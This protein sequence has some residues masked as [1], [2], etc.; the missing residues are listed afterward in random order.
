MSLNPVTQLLRSN[1]L[2][3]ENLGSASGLQPFPGNNSSPR[4]QMF[5]SQ[6]GQILV[7]HGADERF[8]QTGAESQY[9]KCTFNVAMPVDGVVTKVIPKLNTATLG[10]QFRYDPTKLVIW[11]DYN[12]RGKFGA[13]RI[14]RYHASHQSFGFMYQENQAALKRLRQDQGIDAGTV[15]MQSPNVLP[16]GGYAYGKN[17][18]VAF[19]SL[20]ATDNDG[21]IMSEDLIPDFTSTGIISTHAKWGAKRYPLNLYG[22]RDR[23]QPFPNVGD[24]IRPDGLLFALREYRS[25]MSVTEMTPEALMEVD[26][27]WDTLY[28]GK[29]NGEVVDVTVH[30]PTGKLEPTPVGMDAQVRMYLNCQDQYYSRIRE[31]Y[32]E[33]RRKYRDRLRLT[34]EFHNLMVRA[35]AEDTN[36]PGYVVKTMHKEPLDDWHIQL[37]YTYDVVPSVGSKLTDCMGGKGV[38]VDIRKAENMPVDDWGRRAGLIMD[39]D[40]TINRMN[41]GRKFEHDL[42]WTSAMVLLDIERI[43]HEDPAGF[44][45]RA[46]DLLMQ[47]YQCA[48]IYHYQMMLE[49]YQDSGDRIRHVDYVTQYKDGIHLLCPPDR[50]DAGAPAQRAIRSAFPY[51]A[52]PVTFRNSSGR[53]VR[54]RSPVKIGS[55]YIINLEKTGEDWSAVSATKLQHFGIPAMI[56]NEDKFSTPGREQP[57][58]FTGESETRLFVATMGGDATA[59]IVDRPN[60]PGGQKLIVKSILTADNPSDIKQVLDR[61]LCPLGSNRAL[62]V[63]THM[64]RCG[65]IGFETKEST[66]VAP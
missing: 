10:S 17:V 23:Y 46:W 1:Q 16:N 20:A 3:L 19:M 53:V 43:R 41:I 54:T 8:I 21:I 59:D 27:I 48:S 52:S 58:K 49:N 4:E 42:N 26:Y 56:T 64:L 11:E 32:E 66:H 37:T 60:M 35:L 44:Y 38:V 2:S 47:Y 33:L 61:S 12:D 62:Q 36:Q 28:Y 51:Q 45:E 57:V 63:I 55:M 29:P 30:H 14:D 31:T 6:V 50:L 9:G 40:S 34:P 5:T 24:K 7:I 22:T 65:G 18:N 13:L 15:F 39:P 25:R